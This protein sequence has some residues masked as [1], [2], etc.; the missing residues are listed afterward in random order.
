MSV[1]LAPL[2]RLLDDEHPPHELGVLVRKLEGSSSSA[3]MSRFGGV[4][5]T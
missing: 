3:V 4:T 2:R 1:P 5:G